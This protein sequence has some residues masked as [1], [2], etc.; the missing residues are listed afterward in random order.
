V[1]NYKTFVL[2]VS[3]VTN[4]INTHLTTRNAHNS[5]SLWI[6]QG[7][8]VMTKDDM[9]LWIRS[10]KNRTNIINHITQILLSISKKLK[11]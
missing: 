8:Q 1:Q 3:L 11:M 7:Y 5:H 10:V 2:V 6:D 4:K 9:T